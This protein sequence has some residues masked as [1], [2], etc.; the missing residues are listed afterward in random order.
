MLE[1]KMCF[2]RQ[3]WTKKCRQIQEVK[4]RLFYEIF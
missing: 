2:L 1:M 3:S 4:F